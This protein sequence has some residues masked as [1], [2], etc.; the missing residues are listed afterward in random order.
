MKR[1][2][3]TRAKMAEK[4]DMKGSRN[5]SHIYICTLAKVER[6]LKLRILPRPI[7]HDRSH[8][9]P[10]D[11]ADSGGGKYEDMPGHVSLLSCWFGAAPHCLDLLFPLLRCIHRSS[12]LD[13]G[14][15]TDVPNILRETWGRSSEVTKKKRSYPHWIRSRDM[16]ECEDLGPSK[17]A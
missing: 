7:W 4:K 3:E 10:F 17:L 12:T 16:G 15:W 13:E 9:T 6:R 2:A 14:Q 1:I 8:Q 11:L 5:E